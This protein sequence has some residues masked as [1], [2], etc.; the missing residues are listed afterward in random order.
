MTVLSEIGKKSAK[1]CSISMVWFQHQW[2]AIIVI[3]LQGSCMVWISFAILYDSY[4]KV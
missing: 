4:T 3:V 1:S 2:Q